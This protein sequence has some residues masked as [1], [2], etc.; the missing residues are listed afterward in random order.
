MFIFI[1]TIAVQKVT[2]LKDSK[3]ILFV[4][5]VVGLLENPLWTFSMHSEG[6]NDLGRTYKS[7]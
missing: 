6:L 2:S 4:V 1:N 3:N 5:V 7:F